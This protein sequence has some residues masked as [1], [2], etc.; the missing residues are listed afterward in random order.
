MPSR[1]ERAEGHSG[2]GA[3]GCLPLV[4]VVR[5]S[6]GELLALRIGSG[7]GDGAG[8]AISRDDSATSN[9]NLVALLVGERQGLIVDFLVGP[10]IRTRITCDRVVF[11]V[12]LARPLAMGRLAVA[13]GAIRGDLHAVSGGFGDDR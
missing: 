9:S 7:D 11:A 6:A 4:F 1:P 3:I 13:S 12:A 2:S 5:R 10:R 8:L